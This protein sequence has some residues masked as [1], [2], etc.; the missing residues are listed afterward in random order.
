MVFWNLA[1][2]QSRADR[3]Q[4]IDQWGRFFKKAYMKFSSC[5][6][7]KNV[8]SIEG[9]NRSILK[10]VS[11]NHKIF[12]KSRGSVWVSLSVVHIVSKI[13][14]RSLQGALFMLSN[15]LTCVATNNNQCTFFTSNRATG[16]KTQVSFF[17]HRFSQL[18]P[19]S[20]WF[21]VKYFLRM[22]RAFFSTV[23]YKIDSIWKWKNTNFYF[24]ALTS[25]V[26]LWFISI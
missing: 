3:N 1:G 25:R 6:F 16:L 22:K 9:K 11:K 15:L 5:N 24:L 18:E 10:Y 19:C 4:Y 21:V 8:F 13:P 2:S 23:K 26:R 20:L 7:H 14:K 17:P 12:E